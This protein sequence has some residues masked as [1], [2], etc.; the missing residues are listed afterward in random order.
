MIS[1]IDK[2]YPQCLSPQGLP[3]HNPI[4]EWTY[5]SMVSRDDCPHLLTPEIEIKRAA[6]ETKYGKNSSFIRSM[7]YGEFIAGEDDNR[8]YE[9]R[10]IELMRAAMRGENT[11]IKGDV[12]FAGDIAGGGDKT[13]LMGRAGSEV[14]T[15]RTETCGNEI[16]MADAWYRLLRALE[17]PA[18][19]FCVD[20]MGM[21]GTVAHYMESKLGY[22]GIVRFMTGNLPHDDLAFKD[23][24]TELHWVLRELLEF[25]VLKLPFCQQLLQD[26][27][28][29]RY[30]SDALDKVRTE[31]KQGKLGHR[32]RT[33]R[34]P[35]YLDTLI[36]L[37]ADFPMAELR[38]MKQSDEA[39][40]DKK[41]KFKRWEEVDPE[42]T[43]DGV[44]GGLPK[45]DELN[46]E[47]T[48][49]I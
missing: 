14:I 43:E 27:R 33:G 17:I 18:P 7:I 37:L 4:A 32:A 10:H 42:T 41:A 28:D 20:G 26:M 24:Y 11:P 2:F 13:V 46:F 5:R 3:N 9:E 44:F 29:R 36:Y 30:V 47:R 22:W 1:L 6:L 35:D 12:R 49:K 40:K 25:R 45:L 48:A 19:Q 23:R 31:T 38:G 8:I 15:I 39:A 21:G 34:S 16:E